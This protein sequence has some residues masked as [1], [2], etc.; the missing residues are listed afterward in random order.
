MEKTQTCK[1]RGG[2]IMGHFS[3]LQAEI[4]K[5]KNLSQDWAVYPDYQEIKGLKKVKEGILEIWHNCSLPKK[6]PMVESS[7]NKAFV[8]DDIPF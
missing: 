4:E 7:D 3:E 1:S 8:P 6:K 2:R 5:A